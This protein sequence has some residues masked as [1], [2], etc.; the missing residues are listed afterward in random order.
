MCSTVASKSTGA[1]IAIKQLRDHLIVYHPQLA[2]AANIAADLATAAAFATAAY[3]ALATTTDLTA[4][5]RLLADCSRRRR[6]R[7]RSRSNRRRH[8]RRR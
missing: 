5:N 1:S 4:V 8:R 7:S 2:A 3:A 6:L